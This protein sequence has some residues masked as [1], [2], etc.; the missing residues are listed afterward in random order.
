MTALVYHEETMDTTLVWLLSLSMLGTPNTTHING[1]RFPS[2]Q[3][4][5]KALEERR[6]EAKIDKKQLIGTCIAK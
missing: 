5:L 4:C 6:K 3:E 2:K 1:G